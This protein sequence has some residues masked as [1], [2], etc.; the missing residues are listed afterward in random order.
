[1]IDAKGL[2]KHYGTG[3]QQ[4][5]AVDQVDLCVE[6]ADFVSIIGHSGSGK[7]TLL[8]LIGGL[9]RPTAGTVTADGVDIWD[10]PD[11]EL[12]RLRNRR[13]GFVYQFSSLIPTLT[14]L[15]NVLLPVAFGTSVPNA[16]ARAMELLSALGM[17]DRAGAY[18]GQLSGG[19][20]RRVA[21]AR[22]FINEP[23]VVLAD[24][25]TG[26]LDEETEADVLEL[27]GQMNRRGVAFVLVTHNRELAALGA[28][29]LKMDHGH[30]IHL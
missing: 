28:T 30:L 15:E 21:I 5:K 4:V 18:P 12:A 27:F 20:Q 11:R 14:A 16:R 3:E 9:A 19:E 13:I 10:L 29:R 6:P 1:M 2:C 7:S 24:E 8:S 23:A 22:S 26:D 25:P 17:A